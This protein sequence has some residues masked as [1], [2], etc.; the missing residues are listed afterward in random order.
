MDD[1]QHL[2]VRKIPLYNVYSDAG[3]LRIEINRPFT[4]I[5]FLW[6]ITKQ[7][8]ISGRVLIFVNDDSKECIVSYKTGYWEF[9]KPKSPPDYILNL[10]VDR[11]SQFGFAP[12]ADYIVYLKGDAS[13]TQKN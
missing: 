10:I 11:V 8:K 13:C 2:L 12:I 6:E 5:D 3:T 1:D 4:L 7:W 9:E